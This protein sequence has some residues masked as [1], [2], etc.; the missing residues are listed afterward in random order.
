[1]SAPHRIPA[2]DVSLVELLRRA[3]DDARTLSRPVLATFVE[4]LATPELR[5]LDFFERAEDAEDRVYWARPGSGFAVAGIGAALTISP[6]GSDRFIDAA[7]EWRALVADSIC[8]GPGAIGA[9]DGRY[10]GRRSSSPS[11]ASTFGRLPMLLGGFRFDPARSPAPEW[12]GFPDCRLVVPRLCFTA[13]PGGAWLAS[14]ALVHPGDDAESVAAGVASVAAGVSGRGAVGEGNYE[15]GGREMDSRFRGNDW[16]RGSDASRRNDGLRGDAGRCSF[17]QA[18]SSGA[19]AVRE[20]VLEKVVTARAVEW[21]PDVLPRVADTLRRLER[22]HAECMVFAVTRGGRTFLGASPERLVKVEGR[23]VRVTSLAGSTARGGDAAGD[24]D[25]ATA[26]LDSAKDREE[27]DIVVRALTAGLAELCDAVSAPAVPALLTLRDVHH[28]Y[29]PI[30]AH[31]HDD[32]EILQLVE[33]LHPSP[34]VGG[35]PRQ[36]A[37]AFIREH[38]RWDRGWYAS[39]VGWLDAGGDGEFAVALR[40]ALVDEA[41]GSATLFAGC[42]IVGES[43][44]EDEFMESELKLRAMRNALA[45]VEVDAS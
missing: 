10:P 33:R 2:R 23:I 27:H 17:M 37:L 44:P 8:D 5:P 45:D 34:A 11:H 16:G 21:R 39:P 1:M 40:S 4:P 41:G 19:A 35:A 32:V 36:D 26:L 30:T 12:L 42:G 7:R 18:V 25:A 20:G 22:H 14:S 31:R 38:E 28:L 29:T 13:S 6:S 43:V 15:W 9:D 3:A 24:A